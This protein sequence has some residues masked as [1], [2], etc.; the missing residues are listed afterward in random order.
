MGPIAEV[1]AELGPDGMAQI[2]ELCREALGPGPF[3]VEARAW[4]ALGR[5]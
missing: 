2:R 4:A 1:L 5:A 3:T